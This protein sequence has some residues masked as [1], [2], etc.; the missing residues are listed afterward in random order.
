VRIAL[1]T[2]A[3][4][5]Q[6][7]GV[8]T[9]LRR[10][11]DWASRAGHEI[12][13]LTPE[14]LAH[15]PCPSYPEIPLTLR[16]SRAVAAF[17]EDDDYDAIHIATEGPLGIA[18]RALCLRRGRAFTTSY[19]TQFP[20]YVSRRWP[21]PRAVGYAY[22]RWFHAP[23]TRTLVGTESLR[24]S[25]RAQG[26]RGLE[27]WSRGVDTAQFSPR[28]RDVFG[29]VPRPLMLYAGRVA[30]EKNIEDFLDLAVDGTK[31]VVGDGPA[32][33]RLRARYPAVTFT[34]YKYGDE[35]AAALS[36]ADVFVFPSRTDTFGLVMLE[37]MAC[38][39]PVAA[40]PVTGPADV[41][42]EG[43]SGCLHPDLATAVR[44]A[45]RL[46]R[47]ACRAQAE[48]HTWARATQQFLDALAPARGFAY[49]PARRARAVVPARP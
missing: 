23:A 36:A 47:A 10:T 38:G 49:W 46:S 24:A 48:A 33:A 37:A 30:V 32:L 4:R 19:H 41:V 13:P 5:P 35:L 17:F 7:N 42:R 28:P 39:V 14:G 18:A 27:I 45:L 2:D 20:E 8:V 9:T 26:F 22:M 34:G 40:Y 21:I 12:R 3:W 25:L 31:V 44:G 1:V 11:V 29:D 6:T 16:P 15:V 43:I